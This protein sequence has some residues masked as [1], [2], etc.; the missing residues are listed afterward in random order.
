M[1]TMWC[2]NT[3]TKA[4]LDSFF[5]SFFL[6]VDFFLW[7]LSLALTKNYLVINEKDLSYQN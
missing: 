2:V 5:L 4:T 1:D 7:S 3:L 6:L